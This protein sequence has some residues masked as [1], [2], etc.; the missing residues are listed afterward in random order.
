[1]STP[2]LAT[3]FQIDMSLS[4]EC[5]DKHLRQIA[6]LIAEWRE[7]APELGL[8][9]QDEVNITGYA[10]FSV[11]VQKL[12][13]LRM[14]RQKNGKQ[15]TYQRLADAFGKCARQDLVDKISDLVLSSAVQQE[16]TGNTSS[17]RALGE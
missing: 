13:M 4:K 10:P 5:S 14:W 11:P 16:L 1:M 15:A 7:V 6:Q 2:G 17:S 12:H 3:S 9:E 8:T